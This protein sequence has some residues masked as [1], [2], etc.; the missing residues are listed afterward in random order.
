MKYNYP[1]NTNDTNV[2]YMR[3]REGPNHFRVYYKNGAQIRFTPKEVGAVFGVARFTPSVNEIRDWCYK[4][5]HEY[6]SDDDKQD[7]N[8]LKYIEKQR[9]SSSSPMEKTPTSG[10]GPEVHSDEQSLVEEPNDNTKMVT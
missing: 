7:E 8:Y 3:T 9:S 2:T 5:I 10:F 4:M 6:G 1:N